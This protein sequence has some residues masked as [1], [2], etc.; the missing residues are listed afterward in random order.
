MAALG[1]DFSIII[2]YLI[3]FALLLVILRAF[4]YK[5]VL[6]M[7]EKRKQEIANGLDAANKVKVEAERERAKFQ[8]DLEQARR[9]SQEEAT[10]IAQVTAGMREQILA[11][12]HKE[13]EEIK[14]KAR[15]EMQAERQAMEAEL[16]RQIA[17]L[18][19]DLT[20]KVVSKNIDE[21]TQRELVG[22]FLAEMGD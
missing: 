4:A 11:E 22:N 3:N 1:F 14:A 10:K 16:R 17:G 5:P 9:S 20:R 7:L 12:A 15:A 19:V 8:A 18:T 21:K 13:A 6:A 2:A